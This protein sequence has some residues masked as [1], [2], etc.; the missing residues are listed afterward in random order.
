MKNRQS[1]GFLSQY[2]GIIRERIGNSFKVQ[3]KTKE[4]SR[5]TTKQRRIAILVVKRS[6][7]Q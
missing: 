3:L 5:R 4:T 7:S 6:L 1:K 2:A